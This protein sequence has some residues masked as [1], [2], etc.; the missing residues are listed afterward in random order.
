MHTGADL[1]IADIS[2]DKKKEANQTMD[3][4]ITYGASPMAGIPGFPMGPMFGAKPKVHENYNQQLEKKDADLE[5]TIE[6]D[7]MRTE[8][9]TEKKN[10]DG[11]HKRQKCV[12]C[13]KHTHFQC[14]HHACQ[15]QSLR[16]LGQTHY[17]APICSQE[18]SKTCFK[19]HRQEMKKQQTHNLLM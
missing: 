7:G 5:S 18:N 2:K 13:N 16:K 14:G 11:Q 15:L 12:I 19:K 4:M 10:A 3:Q 9:K 17:G 8:I 6:D 1:A